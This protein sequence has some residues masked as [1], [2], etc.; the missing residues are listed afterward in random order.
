MRDRYSM[1]AIALACCAAL[2]ACEGPAGPMGATGDAG[3]AGPQGDPGPAGEAGPQGEEGPQGDPGERGPEGAPGEDGDEGEQGPAGEE[4]PQGEAGPEGPAGPPG[5][6]GEDGRDGSDGRSGFY[7]DPDLVVTP[8]A[9]GLDGMGHATVVFTLSDGVGRPLDVD[10]L[11]TRGPVDLAFTLAAATEDGWHSYIVREAA[12]GDVVVEQATS[13][14]DG[15]LEM[16]AFGEYAYTYETAAPDD[17]SLDAVHRVSI[18]ARRTQD[19]GFRVGHSASLDF[20]P[21]DDGPPIVPDDALTDRCNQCHQ[22]IEG[23]GGR[24]TGLDACVTCHTRQTT[25]PESGNTVQMAVML[26]KIHQGAGL[27]SVQAGEPYRIIGYR[28][29]VHDYSD[30]HLPRPASDCQACHGPDA[31][32][33]PGATDSACAACHDRTAF[34]AP[35]PPGYVAHPGGVRPPDDANCVVCHPKSG[36][37]SGVA[38]VHRAPTLDPALGRVGLRFV[39][40]GVEG[41]APGAAPTVRFRVL[42]DADDPVALDALDS[43]EITL[44]GPTGGI[45]WS[46]TT[47]DVHLSAEVDGAGHVIE[48][49]G[50]VPADATG[51]VAVGMAGYRYLPYGAER[52]ASI[53]RENGGNPVVYAALDDG[54][55]DPVPQATSDARCDACHGDVAAHGTFRT[56]LPYCQLCHHREATDAARRPPEAGPPASVDLG[57]MVHRIH[58]GATLATPVVYYGFG[59]TAHDFGEVHYPGDLARCDGCHTGDRWTRPSTAACVSCHDADAARAHAALE[60]SAE[61]VEACAVCHGPDREYAVEAV[62]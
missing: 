28:G 48:L 7:T 41:A 44:A 23:H 3:P 17:A 20:V 51:S 38:D 50:M 11:F 24:W 2:L 35:T 53:G 57:P 42:D 43:L 60:T 46:H 19:D 27:P 61:G 47:R 36:G 33:W 54:P 34:F 32:A 37:L 58:A 52:A 29:S 59:N 1:G 21:T 30:V 22:G 49:D 5:E 14:S 56:A 10:G 62:H 31:V 18:G 15:A 6:D 39:I 55:A 40:D 45:T 8:T 16:L 12:A 25:D 13:E 26:H 4:G 9:V